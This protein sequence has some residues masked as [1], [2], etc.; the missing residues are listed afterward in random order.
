LPRRNEGSGGALTGGEPPH[1]PER[2]ASL[3]RGYPKRKLGQTQWWNQFR[4]STVDRAEP[5][6]HSSR[7]RDARR[8]DNSRH[9]TTQLIQVSQH[10]RAMHRGDKGG[11]DKGLHTKYFAIARYDHVVAGFRGALI[12][13]ARNS[14]RTKPPPPDHR[15]PNGSPRCA[16]RF[17]TPNTDVDHARVAAGN[18]RRGC[19]HQLPRPHPYLC[20]DCVRVV[21]S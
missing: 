17:P 19:A 14:A 21:V 2:G 4:E 11:H 7:G 13:T 5:R 20:F 9:P 10:T 15:P 18:F 6:Q 3:T 12:A 1:T 16:R 8:P